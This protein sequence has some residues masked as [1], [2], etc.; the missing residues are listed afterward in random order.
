[1]SLSSSVWHS[2]HGPFVQ[3]IQGPSA[4]FKCRLRELYP[5]LYKFFSTK[6]RDY[7]SHFRLMIIVQFASEFNTSSSKLSNIHHW[8]YYSPKAS[9]MPNF[10]RSLTS[11]KTMPITLPHQLTTFTLEGRKHLFE[12][13]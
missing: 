10:C 4:H 8:F 6:N 3:I 5:R 1:M 13:Q 2:N 9:F 12:Y 11:E 7:H